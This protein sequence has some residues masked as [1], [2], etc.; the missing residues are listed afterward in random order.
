MTNEGAMR[1]QSNI[2]EIRE[3]RANWTKKTLKYSNSREK[4]KRV[5]KEKME[6]K[7]RKKSEVGV[8]EPK[9]E[10]HSCD[11]D[12]CRQ[13]SPTQLKITKTVH[14]HREKRENVAN[15]GK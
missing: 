9:L 11:S 1:K 14:N 4:R 6:Q 2:P 15:K 10:R 12:E 7:P 8:K 13:F 3:H 5:K